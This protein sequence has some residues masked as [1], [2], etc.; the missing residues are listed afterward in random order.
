MGTCATL[1]RL[2]NPLVIKAA[3][4]AYCSKSGQ[5]GNP[6]TVKR[7]TT[8][9]GVIKPPTMAKQCCN[10]I[11]AARKIGI[12]SSETIVVENRVSKRINDAKIDHAFT[13]VGWAHTFAVKVNLLLWLREEG[14]VG[15][16]K[17]GVIILVLVS[18]KAVTKTQLGGWFFF[19]HGEGLSISFL[20]LSTIVL[21]NR[22]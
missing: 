15:H 10:P 16:A 3:E 11:S 18:E 22:Q 20:L 1:T 6:Q 8:R 5:N 2:Q 13:F 17:S 4:I 14:K 9:G 7:N 12:G 19:R 21:L